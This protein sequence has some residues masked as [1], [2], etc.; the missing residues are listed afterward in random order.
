MNFFLNLLRMAGLM[1]LGML[2]EAKTNVPMASIELIILWECKA[3]R[4]DRVF[5]FCF[6]VALVKDQGCIFWGRYIV[7]RLMS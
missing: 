6:Q 7:L 3:D 2:V 4:G 5:I 1:S